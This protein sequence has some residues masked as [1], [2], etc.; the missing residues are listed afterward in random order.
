MRGWLVAAL[1]AGASCGQAN[2]AKLCGW[3]VETVGADSEHDVEF[4]LQS[5]EHI[6]FSY[7]MTGQ[8]FTADDGSSRMYSPGSG[9]FSLEPGKAERAWSFG[10]TLGAGMHIDIV[11]EIHAS[12]A[13]L[14]DDDD[15]STPLLGKFAYQRAVTETTEAPPAPA[16]EHECFE[17]KFPVTDFS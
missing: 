11:G 6:T 3:F 16:S 4:W 5:D 9:T 7:A 15:A 8:G 17:A 12:K 2:A 10:A 13:K 14:F 1:I